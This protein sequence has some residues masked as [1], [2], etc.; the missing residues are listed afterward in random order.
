MG[1]LMMSDRIREDMTATVKGLY[2]KNVNND[3]PTEINL[4]SQSGSE[5]VLLVG[6]FV[7]CLY[8]YVRA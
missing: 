2:I 4:G 6:A 8:N 1:L 3:L 5:F 7:W